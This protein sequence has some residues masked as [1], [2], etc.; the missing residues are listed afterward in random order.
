MPRLGGAPVIAKSSNS[1]DSHTTTG[2]TAVRYVRVTEA[3]LTVDE[4]AITALPIAS[5]VAAA[6]P[7]TSTG[8]SPPAT[9][10]S[11]TA[12]SPTPSVVEPTTRRAYG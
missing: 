4:T 12:A 11:R 10:R 3:G 9:S 2:V 7:G 6:G 1:A 8:M 5:P